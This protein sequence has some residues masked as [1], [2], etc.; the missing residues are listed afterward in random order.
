[1]RIRRCLPDENEAICAIINEGAPAYRGVIPPDRLHDPYM[2][3]EELRREIEAGV[4]F[5]GDEQDGA[6]TG[7]MG[8]QHVQDV[9][10][11]RHA[12]VRTAMQG[13]GVGSR[14]LSHLRQSTERPVLI[15]AWADAIWAIRFYEKH[16]FRQVDEA[17]K[18]RLLRRYWNVPDRQI[19]TSVVLA[20]NARAPAVRTPPYKAGQ[21]RVMSR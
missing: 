10:L 6:L 2:P 18:T 20:D 1:M 3:L 17:T 7:V 14:L 4:E 15:G 9:T 16:G 11:I 8:I 13:T 21:A 5:W 19:E 12:Y